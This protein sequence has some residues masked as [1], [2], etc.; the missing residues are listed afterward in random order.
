MFSFGQ[1]SQST[2]APQLN[3]GGGAFGFSTQPGTSIVPAFGI[4]TGTSTMQP[5]SLVTTQPSQQLQQHQTPVQELHE[6]M[7]S[8]NTYSPQCQFITYFFNLSNPGSV[9]YFQP[10]QQQ[11]WTQELWEE[12]QKNNPDKTIMMPIVAVGFEDLK[13][14][15]IEHLNGKNEISAKLKDIG[16]K[17]ETLQ[18]KHN[19]ET[20]VNLENQK[21]KHMELTQRVIKLMK[22]I[23]VVR[24]RGTMTRSGEEQLKGRLEE[25]KQNLLRPMVR[26]DH[27]KTQY[28]ILKIHWDNREPS[29]AH[30]YNTVDA[31]QLDNIV[32]VLGAEHTG[33]VH[34]IDTL[35]KDSK[36]ID[37]IIKNFN[38]VVRS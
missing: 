35:K 6:L 33:I 18:I 13:K 28:S 26:L 30:K 15:I 38:E 17:I 16:N 24:L 8:W 1:T 4:G 7:N 11:R 19:L 29:V 3:L 21:R 22:R 31:N 14:R 2:A 9:Q 36:D 20:S 25:I 5:T 27:I 12:A 34:G 10:Q 23:Q 37:L 32:K